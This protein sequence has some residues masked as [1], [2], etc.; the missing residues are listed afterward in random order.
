MRWSSLLALLAAALLGVAVV[1]PWAPP[2]EPAWSGPVVHALVETVEAYGEGDAA[3]DPAIWVH[4]DTPE[5]SVVIATNKRDPGGLQVFDLSGAQL[6]FVP[7]GRLNNVDLRQGFP[8]ADGPGTL[9]AATNRTDD[10]IEFF[11]LDPQ[12][13]KLR[14]IDALATDLTDV[15]GLCL[16]RSQTDRIHAFLTTLG[17][18]IVQYEVAL[19]GERLT[20]E[21]VRTFQLGSEGEGCVADDEHRMLYLTQEARGLWRGAAEPD[22]PD[23]LELVADTL[24]TDAELVADVEGVTVYDTGGGDGYLVVSSQGNSSFAVYDRTG[25]NRYLGSFAVRGRSEVDGA[26]STDGVA[27]TSA[28]LGPQFPAGLLVVHDQDNATGATS[29]FKYV[30][31]ADVERVLGLELASGRADPAARLQ[32]T[33]DVRS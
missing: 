24:E 33:G 11:R 10:T 3:D 2:S 4:P 17:G 13:R 18:R 7:T 28:P 16:Y 1:G 8:F 20:M 25:A 21:P 19:S 9:V 26:S 27:V 14:P 15:Y 30:S 12:T 32:A 29:N 6:Q 22:Q 23:T 31:W 5:R